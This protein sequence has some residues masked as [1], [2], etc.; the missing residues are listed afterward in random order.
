MSSAGTLGFLRQK[1]STGWELTTLLAKRTTYVIEGCPRIDT[2]Y[3][4]RLTEDELEWCRV[5]QFFLITEGKGAMSLGR[6]NEL[7]MLWN[8]SCVPTQRFSTACS[9]SR[10]LL[11]AKACA[12][13]V[14]DVRSRKSV[15]PSFKKMSEI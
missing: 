1:E 9:Q 3:G 14:F 2:P 15:A 4:G 5:N 12:R 11:V 7:L 13:E 6:T 8:K 10:V